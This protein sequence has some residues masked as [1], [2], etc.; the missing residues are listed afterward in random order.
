M[1]NLCF[2]KKFFENNIS[3]ISQLGLSK[4]NLDSL[5]DV[6]QKT[7]ISCN[8]LEWSGLRS[9]IPSHMRK[10]DGVSNITKLSFFRKDAFYDVS[11]AKSKQHYNLLIQLKG[12]LPNAAKKLKDKFNI[13]YEDLSEVYL[14]PLKVC[15]ETFLRDFQFKVLNYMTCTKILLKKI[16][17]VDSDICSFC[18][19]SREEIEHMLFNCSVSQTF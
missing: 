16:G 1:A 15:I 13:K 3:L 6:R 18:N 12:T 19:L 8:F 11:L 5:D 10:D 4:N 2:I 7:N 14:L 17:V 9:A